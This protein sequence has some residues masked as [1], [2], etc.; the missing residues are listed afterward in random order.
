MKIVMSNMNGNSKQDPSNLNTS[1]N[2]SQN[3]GGLGAGDGERQPQ[4]RAVSA[5]SGGDQPDMSNLAYLKNLAGALANQGGG[6]GSGNHNQNSSSAAASAHGFPGGNNFQGSSSNNNNNNNNNNNVDTAGGNNNDFHHM[7]GN[8]NGSDTDASSQYNM[9]RISKDSL[10]S[11]DSISEILSADQVASNNLAM[12]NMLAN[13]QQQQ[14]HQQMGNQN[15]GN[16]NNNANNQ[17]HQ[18]LNQSMS[19]L[20]MNGSMNMNA[21]ASMMNNSM[22]GWNSNNSNPMNMNDPSLLGAYGVEGG[23]RGTAPL[24][25]PPK[26]T[27]NKHKQTFAQKL[28]HILS[29]KECH[30]SIRW[31]PNGC[32]FCIVDSKLLVET[33]LPKY[34]KEAKYTSFVRSLEDFSCISRCLTSLPSNFLT[35]NMHIILTK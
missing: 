8:N 35:H 9:R 23:G 12:M 5:T 6:D 32:A 21:A 24:L 28:M 2:F 34:F 11:R 27:K 25:I 10:V 33:V 17:Q 20:I 3:A 4:Q 1:S 18:A 19:Q 31:M 16:F 30:S 29:I 7:Q 26:K 14:Q 15:Y 22:A 13:Q